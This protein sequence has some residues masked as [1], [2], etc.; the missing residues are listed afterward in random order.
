[1]GGPEPVPGAPA[2]RESALRTLGVALLVCGACASLIAASVVWLRPVQKANQ[3]RDRRARVLAMMRAA[4][5]LGELV[6]NLEAGS[7]E[8]RL[9]ELASGAWADPGEDTVWDVRQLAEPPE[10]CHPL[11]EDHDPAEI[12]CVPLV[13]PVYVVAEGGALRL[14][15]LPIWG[16]G[17]ASAMFGY[18]ALDGDLDTVRSIQFYEHEET[19]G[20]GAEI[21]SEGWRSQWQGKRLRDESG[22]LRIQV[23][24]DR[25]APDSP[26]YPYTVD[27]ISGATRTGRAVTR[28][29][30]FWLGPEGYGPLLERLAARDEG[31]P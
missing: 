4:P 1:M 5:G 26:D 15:I 18:L 27:G 9:V 16:A 11:D 8:P 30:R 29:V 24:K 20:L 10:P 14:L 17:Y 7:L 23:A 2:P 19:P 25:V 3:E 28:L 12:G 21:E 22:A 6:A 31:R 13:V